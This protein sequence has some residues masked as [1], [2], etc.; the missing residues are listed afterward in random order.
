MIKDL[1]QETAKG[2][3]ESSGGQKIETDG[4]PVQQE[5][6]TSQPIVLQG[7]IKDFCDYFNAASGTNSQIIPMAAIIPIIGTAI[8]NRL[9]AVFEGKIISPNIYVALGAPSGSGKD[10]CQKVGNII[11]DPFKAMGANE[12]GS[13]SAIISDLPYQQERLDML[14]EAQSFFRKLSSKESWEQGMGLIL[15][16]LFGRASSKYEGSKIMKYGKDKRLGACWNPHVSILAS[17]TNTIE[18][19]FTDSL[20]VDGLLARFLYFKEVNAPRKFD[21]G[22]DCH[23]ILYENIIPAFEYIRTT[24]PKKSVMLPIN[25]D[26]K[27]ED[28][29][30]HKYEP[31]KIGVAKS[32]LPLYRDFQLFMDAKY[33]DDKLL[34]ALARRSAELVLKLALI[35]S[36]SRGVNSGLVYSKWVVDVVD[37]EFGVAVF[38]QSFD[39]YKMA[40]NMRNLEATSQ[41]GYSQR[42]HKMVSY[43]KKHPKSELTEAEIRAYIRVFR[44]E[45]DVKIYL[46]DLIIFGIVEENI[47]TI[48][49][50]RVCRY[51]LKNGV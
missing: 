30:G 5:E 6:T 43:F 24:L 33:A 4:S 12:Y 47:T 45:R 23:K 39:N 28:T 48:N 1:L 17:G 49:G 31:V 21:L 46:N 41:D 16:T 37:W 2:L 10:F 9:C 35:N 40:I 42:R 22:Q 38:G 34:I 19:H 27:K 11:L 15:Q 25:S 26:D 51:R 18:E 14:D 50:K 20:F 3:K 36:V 44:D 13:S 7:L 8:S 29:L 32:I